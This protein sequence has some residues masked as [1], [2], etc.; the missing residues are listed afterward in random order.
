MRPLL[1]LRS[2]AFLAGYATITIVWGTLGI[3]CGWLLPYRQRF[4][5]IVVTWT[6]LVLGWLRLTCG[7]RA[8]VEGREHI[9]AAPCVVLVRHESTWETLFLQQLL[10]P[11]TT[12]IKRELLRI[13]FFGWAYSLLR[14]IAIDRADG[15]GALRALVRSGRS[16]LEEGIWVMLFPE[17]TRLAP[18][19]P[20]RFQRGGAALATAA[21][22]PVLVVAH[23]AGRCW[24]ARRWLKY[25]GTIRLRISPPIDTGGRTTPQ[26]TEEAEAWMREALAELYAGSGTDRAERAAA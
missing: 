9:P 10:V 1:A 16:R 6:R 22:V 20:G 8:V 11:Q 25:P 5:F 4:V 15:R 3:L 17:G 12:V 19:R 24:P 13:P 2:L 23:D 18:G 21:G 14:P 26:V 7:I